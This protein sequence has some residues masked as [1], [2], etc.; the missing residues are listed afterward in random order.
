VSEWKWALEFVSFGGEALSAYTEYARVTL[1][2]GDYQVT[3]AQIARR[4]RMNIG[5]ITSDGMLHVKFQSGGRLG[6][7]EEGFIAR[8]KPG[9]T[10]IFA[11]RLLEFR[12]IKDM[13]VYVRKA[14][15]SKGVVPRWLGG[16]LPLSSYLAD[17][18][19]LRLAAAEL[20]IYDTPEMIAV[21]PILEIQQ[22]WSKI[23]TSGEL[24]IEEVK[25]RE[26]YHLFLYPLAGQLVH[27]GFATLLAFRLSRLAPRTIS[28]FATDYGCELLSP[29]PLAVDR[30]TWRQLLSTEQLLDDILLSLNEMEITRR[31]FRDIARIAGLVFSG[32]PGSQKT[33]RQ[34]QASSGVIFDVFTQYDPD[35]L[36]LDQARREVLEEQLEINRLRDLLEKLAQ[37]DLQIVTPKRLTPLAFPLW[38]SR[39]RSQ[40]STETWSDRIAR[41]VI[42]LEKAA[43]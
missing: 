8:I 20:G 40:V 29:T 19:R 32:Y 11:G 41:M 38:A 34:L 7:I 30:A 12:R 4:H 39:M 22:T 25:T 33:T 27:E 24:L 31:Q 17:A 18:V 28:T 43:G 21:Q 13:T 37:A 2:N 23:P 35:N 14:K 36:L 16:R 1:Q 42:Q 9:D 26:G 5:T 10:F 6:A 15:Q 3:S